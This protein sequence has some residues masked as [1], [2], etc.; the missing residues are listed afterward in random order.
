MQ[1]FSKIALL[2]DKSVDKA[3]VCW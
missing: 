3:K 1:G 2:C